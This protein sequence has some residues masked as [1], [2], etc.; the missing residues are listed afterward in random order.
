MIES[1]YC[2]DD[3][4]HDGSFHPVIHHVK[5]G[6]AHC[7]QKNIYIF[8]WHKLQ[9]SKYTFDACKGGAADPLPSP[10]GA[11]AAS[12][13]WGWWGCTWN[14]RGR[15]P[16][17]WFP[18]ESCPAYWCSTSPTLFWSGLTYWPTG[19][20]RHTQTHAKAFTRADRNCDALLGILFLTTI[21]VTIC[22]S[23]HTNK[24]VNET[25]CFIIYQANHS[26]WLTFLTVY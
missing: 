19:G 20:S 3:S 14:G 26:W 12:C 1:G 5:V 13:R 22:F 8:T 4:K 7:R 15:P 23:Y 21:V 10:T 17:G 24:N 25:L 9:T 18:G 2:V 11:S 16:Q 6:Q